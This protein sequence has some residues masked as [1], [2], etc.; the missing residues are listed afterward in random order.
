[1]KKINNQTLKGFADWKPEEFAKRNYI[2]KVFRKISQNYGFKEYLTPILENIEIYKAKSGEDIGGKELM[3]CI[4]RAGRELAIRPEMTPSVTRMVTQT[5]KSNVKPIKLFSIAN[6]VRNQKPQRG[7]NREFWQLN[8]DIFGSDSINA[9]LEILKMALDIMLEFNPPEDSF[10]LYLNNR[11]LIDEILIDRIKI[12]ETV[13]TEVVRILDKS[14]KL[15][16]EDFK[17]RLSKLGLNNTDID[18]LKKFADSKTQED[19][20]NNF[21]KIEETKGFQET[22]ELYKTLK[23]LKYGDWIEFNPSIIRGFDYYDGMVFEVFDKNPKNNRSLFGGGRYNGLA[24]IFG[25]KPFPAVGCA[26]GDETLKLFLEEW[27]LFPVF[28]TSAKVLVTI[29]NEDLREDSM[30]FAD[31]LRK[32]GIN[33]EIYLEEDKLSNQFSYA[34]QKDIPYV[35]II[36]PDEVEKRVISIKNFKT[37]E[38][39]TDSPENIIK[40]LTGSQKSGNH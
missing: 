15:S 3:T 23:E 34:D 12:D 1:M 26:P 28:N 25:E 22:V 9:D 19:L 14:G 4:D 38:E 30:R 6:F 20:K 11:K 18:K 39:N 5:Y 13:K 21:E 10:V 32:E 33:T 17:T 35:V 29:F 36:G 31:K 7:R 8:Y 40:Y 27:D 24:D 16:S 37:G 2:F